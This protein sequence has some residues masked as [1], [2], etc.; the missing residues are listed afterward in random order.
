MRFTKSP[1]ARSATLKIPGGTLEYT[2]RQRARVTR[3]LHMELDEQGGLVVVAPG[4]WSKRHINATLLQNTSRVQRFLADAQQRRL[5]PLQYT[6]GEKHLYK[7]EH[8]TL[9]ITLLEAGKNHIDLA[10][11][12]LRI[13]TH[14]EQPESI[15]H[16]Q[17]L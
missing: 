15:Q 11:S 3:R 12:D 6:N 7:G 17:Y 5:A 9:V 8:Y 1:Q 4:H 16:I 2:I 10:D 13:A 14:V